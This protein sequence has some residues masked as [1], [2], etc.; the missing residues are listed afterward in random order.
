[1]TLA[2]VWRW[3][4]GERARQVYPPAMR[5][6]C[7]AMILAALLESSTV[8]AQSAAGQM[9]ST[10]AADFS[11]PRN[12]KQR[13]GRGQELRPRRACPQRPMPHVLAGVGHHH[14]RIAGTWVSVV[15]FLTAVGWIITNEK[16][17]VRGAYRIRAMLRA[18]VRTK[19][20]SPAT[21]GK[22]VSPHSD[23]PPCTVLRT[24]VL[25]PDAATMPPLVRLRRVPL[26]CGCRVADIHHRPSHLREETGR[27]PHD[28]GDQK[29]RLGPKVRRARVPYT[30]SSCTGTRQ[31]ANSIAAVL[32]PAGGFCV[33]FYP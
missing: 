27:P 22:L 31:T 18:A 5:V 17:A 14:W 13:S 23:S 19:K 24:A 26:S 2:R 16:D 6:L 9:S 15:S 3:V 21:R 32:P 11:P 28:R 12:K 20:A 4:G 7:L 33:P 25:M 8:C 30:M 29:S 1:M 10:S